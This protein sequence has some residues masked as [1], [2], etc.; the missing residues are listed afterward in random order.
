LAGVYK[1]AAAAMTAG[2]EFA[3]VS[4]GPVRNVILLGASDSFSAFRTLCETKGVK[5]IVI[6][7]PDQQQ[8][9][10]NAT[11]DLV[12]E[13]IGSPQ[14]AEKLAGLLIEGE[15]IALS[16]GAR[17]ILKQ[18][19]R[20]R[21]FRGLVLNAHGT[22]LPNDR[23]GG[24]FSWRIMRGDRIGNLVLHQINDGIDTGPIVLSE[25]YLV[26]RNIQTP[27]EHEKYYLQKLS[28]FVC[29][30]LG[31]I[32][33][34]RCDFEVA[35]QLNHSSSYYPRLHTPTH[36]WI[37]WS[38]SPSEI[39]TF[40]LSFDAPYPGARTLWRD[41]TVV[42][43]NCQLH[44]G[45]IGHHSFQKGLVIRNNQKWLTVALD[46]QY[47]LLVSEARDEAG[48]DL[49]PQIKEGDRLF[50]PQAVLD[51][52]RMTRVQFTATGLRQSA[53]PPSAGGTE[54]VEKE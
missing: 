40:I 15:M 22:R 44:V 14:V 3:M 45:E 35:P 9:M 47:C 50:T 25:E 23:G 42:L 6:T 7:S 46:G 1:T 17:W 4:I 31:R 24:G 20:D 2:Q 49:L 13:D 48:N 18:N 16:F 27:A 51:Q 19:V 41:K 21:L 38:W 34:A 12:T 28:D 10:P 43:R 54:P 37:D 29:G 5:C 52:A 53:R 26:P 33:S 32:V 8:A 30:F 39:D 36:G 11:A